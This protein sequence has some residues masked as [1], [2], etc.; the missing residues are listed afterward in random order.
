MDF[1]DLIKNSIEKK[2]KFGGSIQVNSQRLE[3]QLKL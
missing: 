1:M 2:I 3:T